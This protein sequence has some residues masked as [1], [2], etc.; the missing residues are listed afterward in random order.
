MSSSSGRKSNL[1]E[2]IRYTDMKQAA[3]SMNISETIEKLPHGYNTRM[4]RKYKEGH[5]FSVGQQ[6]RIHLAQI[7]YRNPKMI[8]LDEPNAGLDPIVEAGIIKELHTLS[9]GKT[10]II[11]A[12][13]ILALKHT[14]RILCFENGQI[15]EDGTHEE[16]MGGKRYYWKQFQAQNPQNHFVTT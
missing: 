14:T 3:G 7:I 6:A 10:S 15:I 8:V 5:R 4:S 12:H 1:T 11:V 9:K 13:K 16:L 2:E